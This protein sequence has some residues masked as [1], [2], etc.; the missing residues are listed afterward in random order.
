MAA[1]TT[2]ILPWL[3]GANGRLFDTRWG[4]QKPLR[5]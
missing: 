5:E 4:G 3:C 2:A 1:N